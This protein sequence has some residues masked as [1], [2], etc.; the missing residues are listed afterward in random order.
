LPIK[1]SAAP[2]SIADYPLRVHVYSTHWGRNYSAYYYGVDYG[3][4]GYG[5]ANL[6]DAAN[7]NAMDYTFDCDMHFMRSDSNE[8]FPA[9][10]KKQNHEIE[11]LVGIIGSDKTE[12][13]RLDITLKDTVYRRINGSTVSLT[14]AEFKAREANEAA[15]AVA[16]APSDTDINHYPLKLSLLDVNWSERSAGIYSGLGHGNI[17]GD[18]GPRAVDIA[19]SCPVKVAVTP[20]GRFY[21]GKWTADGTQM[22]ILLRKIGDPTAA[23]TCSLKTVVHEDAY[24]LESAGVLKAVSQERYKAMQPAESATS[25][26]PS[27]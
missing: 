27:K 26:A 8:A 9:R 14:Q 2:R 3:Y 16:L 4:H 6:E 17:F 19:F 18:Q 11:M 1:A 22:D 21:H 15:R 20:D 12:T 24:V 13:C 25:Q 10:W 7:V 23:A 5:R